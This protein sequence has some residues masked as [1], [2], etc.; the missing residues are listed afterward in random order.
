MRKYRFPGRPRQNFTPLLLMDI[1]VLYAGK[2]FEPRMAICPLCEHAWITK[3]LPKMCPKCKTIFY[4][5]EL[6]WLR[7]KI[8][9]VDV[10][11]RDTA[12]DDYYLYESTTLSD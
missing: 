10:Y 7:E 8:V 9:K 1:I 2:F 12:K 11:K 3:A 5:I 6:A 4:Q